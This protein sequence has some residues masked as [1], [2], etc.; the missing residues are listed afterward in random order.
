MA[1]HLALPARLTV[2]S[3]HPVELTIG[4]IG[5]DRMADHRQVADHAAELFFDAVVYVQHILFE[6]QEANLMRHCG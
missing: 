5:H 2:Q 6:L 1:L 4:M 3:Y